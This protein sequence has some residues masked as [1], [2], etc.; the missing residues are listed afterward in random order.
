MERGTLFRGSLRRRKMS[1]AQESGNR[2]GV[3]RR[4]VD[5]TSARYDF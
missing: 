4:V 1:G 3:V 2:Y 5:R